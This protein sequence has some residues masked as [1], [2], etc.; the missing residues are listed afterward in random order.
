[1]RILVEQAGGGTTGSDRR[2]IIRRAHCR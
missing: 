1:V 2:I